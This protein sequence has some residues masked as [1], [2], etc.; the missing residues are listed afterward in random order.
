MRGRRGARG[1]G[2]ETKDGPGG[3][4]MSSRKDGGG[5]C[6]GRDS[7]TRSHG[8]ICPKYFS[9]F[10]FYICQTVYWLIK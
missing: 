9:L 8:S 4:K 7:Q 2:L 5:A 6:V 1:E 3:R 10:Y